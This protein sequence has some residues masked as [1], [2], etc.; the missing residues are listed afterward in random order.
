MDEITIDGE[1]FSGDTLEDEKI[2]ELTD[3]HMIYR[4]TVSIPP[5]GQIKVSMRSHTVKRKLDMEVWSSRVPSEGLT[6]RVRAP[7]DIPIHATANHSEAL[8]KNRTD[9]TSTIWKLDHGIFP[10]QS[11]IFWWKAG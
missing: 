8:Q 10:F 5:A 7:A 9:A 6:L 2:K 1:S 3:T 4:K 11:V